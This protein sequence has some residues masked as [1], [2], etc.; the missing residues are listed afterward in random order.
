MAPA[1]HVQ[2]KNLPISSNRSL[3]L[4]ASLR[5]RLESGQT[6]L[7]VRAARRWLLVLVPI[8]WGV[9]LVVLFVEVPPGPFWVWFALAV[10]AVAAI[11]FAWPRH[12]V[13]S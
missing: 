4:P 2:D 1:I 6:L 10:G 13:E 9:T 3:L 5:N 8:A 12:A 7:S 11:N